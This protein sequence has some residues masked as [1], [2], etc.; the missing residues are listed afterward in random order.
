MRNRRTLRE[1]A[2]WAEYAISENRAMSRHSYGLPRACFWPPDLETISHHVRCVGRALDEVKRPFF[3]TFC[4]ASALL[5]SRPQAVCSALAGFFK[6]EDAG[7]PL[8]W[9]ELSTMTWLGV[10]VPLVAHQQGY[11]DM[12]LLGLFA[13]AS[14]PRLVCYARDG[15][16]RLDDRARQAVDTAATLAGVSGFCFWLPQLADTS[17]SITGGSLGLP[18]YG[19][20]VLLRRGIT[21]W[22]ALVCSGRLD[23]SGALLPVE[24]LPYKMAAARNA[25]YCG[26]IYPAANTAGLN[27]IAPNGLGP[28]TFEALPVPDAETAQVLLECYIP[29]QGFAQTSFYRNRHDIAQVIDTIGRIPYP[30]L[31]FLERQEQFLS[32]FVPHTTLAA[33]HQQHLLTRLEESRRNFVTGDFSDLLTHLFSA[34]TVCELSKTDPLSAW[35]A[36]RLHI[37]QANHQGLIQK[38]KTWE[39]I[40]V[41]CLEGVLQERDIGPNELLLG[42]YSIIS[43]RHNQ[44][45]FDPNVQAHIPPRLN[46]LI[47]TIEEGWQRRRARTP[48]AAEKILGEYY[49]TL[50]QH[51]GFCGP[52]YHDQ[53]EAFTSKA[54][55]AFGNGRYD[56]YSQEWRRVFACRFFCRLDGGNLREARSAL[57]DYLGAE[58]QHLDYSRMNP[59]EHFLLTRYLAASGEA[60]APYR[61]RVVQHHFLKSR[62]ADHPWQLWALNLGRLHHDPHWQ[63]T[64]W[65]T[66]LELCLA[67]SGVTIRIMGLM[68]LARLVTGGLIAD[69][70]A[71]TRIQDIIKYCHHSGLHQAHF[72]PLWDAP[73]HDV[74]ERV[75]QRMARYFP[76]SYR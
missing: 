2:V 15:Q 76:F 58:W 74:A 67:N 24:G 1:L 25:E 51:F 65:E 57:Q 70:V 52:Q 30:F 48:F 68:P 47:K 31:A 27:P 3:H 53:A 23:D 61:N 9:E 17:W 19:G 40:A 12:V 55:D 46:D 71:A 43:G 22:P 21:G 54:L 44:Y 56:P 49:G 72:D 20:L 33:G 66:S 18:V 45:D 62:P 34:A 60:C 8:S 37:Q 75:M 29:E 63:Q 36:A 42:I 7:L 64:C 50:G 38:F 14:E 4:L 5:A 13:Q 11:I 39:T 69:T 10:P 16:C 73:W 59:F 6:P 26:F 41:K 28:A 32:R 35:R